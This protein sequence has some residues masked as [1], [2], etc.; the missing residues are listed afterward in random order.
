MNGRLSEEALEVGDV[1]RAAII[2][3]GGTDLLRR[4]VADPARRND[5]GDLLDAIGIWDLDVLG[6][7]VEFEVAAAACHAAGYF[8]LPYPIAERL[9]HA[10]G[11]VA[12][13]S[14]SDREPRVGNH[15]DLGLEWSGID[16]T[17]REYRIAGVSESL[18]GSQI[19]PFASRLDAVPLDTHRPRAAAA[20]ATLQSWWLLG[21]LENAIDK[22]VRYTREREQ[23]GRAL[24]RFQ[25]VGFTL[26]DMIVA[27]QSLAELAK[28]TVWS[29]AQTEGADVALTD[30]LALRVASLASAKVVMRGA[31]QLHG[32]MGFTDEVDVSW[33]SRASQSVRRL[34]EGE[35]RTGE[36]LADSIALT[37]W[38]SVGRVRSI[39]G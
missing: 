8:A 14:V 36:L 6:D 38:D 35:H 2:A 9:A 17:G 21:M 4:A 26:A 33:L 31:H 25:A 10:P 27:S 18:L 23:F 5:A 39:A 28:Y 11:A 19:G 12:T 29:I 22:T 24:I 15:V 3:A 30:A 1:I 32:A 37:G 34:P 20:L 7:Q 16:L 13:V